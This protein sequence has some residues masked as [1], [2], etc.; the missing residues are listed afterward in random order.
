M[1]WSTSFRPQAAGDPDDIFPRA[2]RP[3]PSSRR[4]VEPV[5]IEARRESDG[6]ALEVESPGADQQFFQ[7]GGMSSES[8][9]ET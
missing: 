1:D 3:G 2:S 7:T 9:S 6:W 5:C 8:L 4:R